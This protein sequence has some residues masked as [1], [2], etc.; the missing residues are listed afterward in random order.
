MDARQEGD[1][2]RS[3]GRGIQSQ[4]PRLRE[5]E[6]GLRDSKIALR[7]CLLVGEWR[8]KL[9]PYIAKDPNDP[10]VDNLGV[11]QTTALRTHSSS[12]SDFMAFATPA[13][14]TRRQARKG[15]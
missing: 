4:R 8:D 1:S 2:A 15:R 7:H 10:S 11:G 5:S 14:V 12:A 3:V 6:V 13:A 9:N